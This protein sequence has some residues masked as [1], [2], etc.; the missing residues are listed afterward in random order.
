MT[1][2]SVALAQSNGGKVV[3]GGAAVGATASVAN[4]VAM[5]VTVIG[6]GVGGLAVGEGVEVGSCVGI[7]GGDDVT[8]SVNVAVGPGS[9][10]VAVSVMLG[11]TFGDIV[12]VAVMCRVISNALAAGSTSAGTQPAETRSAIGI[13]SVSRVRLEDI[14]DSLRQVSTSGRRCLPELRR[15]DLDPACL[16]SF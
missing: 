7:A 12:T 1:S 10:T 8:T 11:E 2:M 14:M 4:G 15:L 9:D 16:I 6:S 5:G 13:S 3:G